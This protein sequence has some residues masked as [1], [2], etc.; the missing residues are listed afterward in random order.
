[1]LF[2]SDAKRW[3]D[4]YI[5]VN[6]SPVQVR[7]PALLDLVTAV[8]NETGVS[9]S[10]LMLEVTEGVLIENPEDAK[11]RLGALQKLGVKL[12]LDDFGTGYSSLTYLQKF[13]FDKK[14]LRPKIQKVQPELRFDPSQGQGGGAYRLSKMK[15]WLA[16]YLLIQKSAQSI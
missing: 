3:A 2:R 11:V 12:A 10:N 15:H 14:F 6:L 4:L 7:D 16:N 9:P 5:A 13:S 8:L 1:M